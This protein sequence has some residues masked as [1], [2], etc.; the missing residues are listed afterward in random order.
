[1]T[2]VPLEGVLR[3]AIH[4]A[5]APV[6]AYLLFYPDVFVPDVVHDGA[7]ALLIAGAAGAGRRRGEGGAERGEDQSRRE[8]ACLEH[9]HR[10]LRYQAGQSMMRVPRDVFTRTNL[11]QT[12]LTRVRLP[13]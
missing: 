9:G 5:V 8:C 3:A 1:M 11:C 13:C 10:A 4:Q 12:P 7:E 6:L 2:R